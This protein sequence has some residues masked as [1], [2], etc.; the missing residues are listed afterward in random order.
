MPG[1]TCGVASYLWD[2]SVKISFSTPDG[3]PKEG[4]SI[5]LWLKM[6]VSDGERIIFTARGRRFGIMTIKVRLIFKS[7][8]INMFISRIK[9][10]IIVQFYLNLGPKLRFQVYIFII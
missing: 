6:L 7:L 1:S 2:Q 9:P 8:S 4:V 10:A 5:S 3:V